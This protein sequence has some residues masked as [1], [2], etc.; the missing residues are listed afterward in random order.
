MPHYGKN[1]HILVVLPDYERVF[2]FFDTLQCLS[3]L[4]FGNRDLAKRRGGEKTRGDQSTVCGQP[5]VSWWTHLRYQFWMF[6]MLFYRQLQIMRFFL[7]NTS[8]QTNKNAKL[9]SEEYF[10]QLWGS[11]KHRLVG[12]YST[13]NAHP[14]ERALR[15]SLM[16]VGF[17]WHK[18][19]VDYS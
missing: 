9:L 16:I 2:W 15:G 12:S 19:Y 17:W 11:T 7:Q 10:K 5:L 1:V 18:H 3:S 14:N 6:A 13:A 4:R 8:G